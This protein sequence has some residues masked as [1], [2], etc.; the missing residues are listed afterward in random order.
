MFKNSYGDYDA[1]LVQIA[2]AHANG[3]IGNHGYTQDDADDILQSLIVAGISALSQFDSSRGKRSTYLYA[4]LRNQVINLVRYAD[5]KIRD[6][7]NESF[8]FDEKVDEDEI[9]ETL[10]SDIIGIEKTIT[11]DGASRNDH[12]DIHGLRIDVKEALAGLPPQLRELCRLHAFLDSEDARRA[13]GM[14][15]STHHRAIKKIRFHLGKLGF[16]P[17]NPKKGGRD[18]ASI[19]HHTKGP[20]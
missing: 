16:T 8:S 7:Q 11:E 2:K 12:A 6:R 19:T 3:L 9:E 13:A 17:K 15:Y 14:A 5:G 10:W 18:Q 1:E 20:L 4:V